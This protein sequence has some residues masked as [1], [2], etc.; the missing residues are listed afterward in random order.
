MFP[1]VVAA[2][3]FQQQF[4]RDQAILR[5]TGKLSLRKKSID[6]KTGRAIEREMR[7]FERAATKRRFASGQDDRHKR[8]MTVG[9]RHI[10]EMLSHDLGTNQSMVALL[11]SVAVESY[12]AFESLA[13]DLLYTALNQGPPEWRMNVWAKR[14]KF[15]RGS[16]WDPFMPTITRDPQKDWGYSLKESNALGFQRLSK[17]KFWYRVAFNERADSLFKKHPYIDAL[18]A[19]RNV[20]AHNAGKADGHYR[21]KV[22]EFDE[23][24]RVT[25]D[26]LIRLDGEIVR[27]LSNAAISLGQQLLVFVDNGIAAKKA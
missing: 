14:N 21:E 2:E 11:F 17:I 3:A 18:A 1:V 5:V 16:D 24:K 8:R 15:E 22:A 12:T 10:E 7:R 4:W 9:L 27:K 23:L 13:G 26:T 20:I 25:D 19:V 6:E